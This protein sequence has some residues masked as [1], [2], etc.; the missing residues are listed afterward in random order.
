MPVCDRQSYDGRKVWFSVTVGQEPDVE[1]GRTEGSSSRLRC[2]S[3][4]LR[5][6]RRIIG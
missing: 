6:A 5:E 1:V 4:V 3:V 2:Y